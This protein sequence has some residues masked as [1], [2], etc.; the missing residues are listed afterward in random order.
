MLETAGLQLLVEIH[1]QQRPAFVDWLE[2]WHPVSPRTNPLPSN[3][4]RWGG[5]W[6]L[7]GF[8]SVN[9]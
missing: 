8:Y 9:I 1:R 2:S 7:E 5:G 4:A 6:V 3:Y